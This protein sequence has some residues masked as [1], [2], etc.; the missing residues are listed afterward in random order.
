MLDPD[1][2]TDALRRAPGLVSAVVPVSAFGA[3]PDLDRWRAFREI[4]GL[5]VVIDGAAAFDAA[6]DVR[7]PTVISLHATKVL[8]IGEGGYLAS[9][10]GALVERVRQATTYGFRGGR[11]SLRAGTNAKLSEYAA[12]IGH[13]ALDAWP[14]ERL[15]WRRAAQLLRMTCTG[16]PEVTF[17]PGWGEDW[18]TSVCMV[19]LPDGLADAAEAALEAEGVGVRRWWGRG[20]HANPAFADCPRTA[21]PH[22]ERLARSTLGLP[23]AVDLDAEACSRIAT[24]LEPVLR[25]TRTCADSA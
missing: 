14:M 12:A 2:V 4:T 9:E 21:L 24:A 18:V 1:A 7:L 17:Q 8:G 16:L 10:D 3:L 6:R 20:C 19:R 5:P 13:A 23:F 15:R 22:S 11:E 25:R